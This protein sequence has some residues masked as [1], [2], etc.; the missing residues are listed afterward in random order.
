[1]HIF[2]YLRCGRGRSTRGSGHFILVYVCTYS[3]NLE[4][5]HLFKDESRILLKILTR[6]RIRSSRSRFP[7]RQ[8]SCPFPAFFQG[9]KYI[10]IKSSAACRATSLALTVLKKRTYAVLISFALSLFPS[11]NVITRAA[12]IWVCSPARERFAYKQSASWAIMFFISL[13]AIRLTASAL[14][15]VLVIVSSDGDVSIKLS[16]GSSKKPTSNARSTSLAVG[17]MFILYLVFIGSLIRR[18]FL[19]FTGW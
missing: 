3:V 10:G 7:W 5:S 13:L 12:P 17:T 9:S 16:S 18:F 4:E 2:N 15:L 19:F 1:M 11:S 14:S 6:S 8:C